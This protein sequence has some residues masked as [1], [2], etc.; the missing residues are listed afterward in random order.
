MGLFSFW[1]IAGNNAMRLFSF[2]YIVGNSV[3][4]LFSF[5]YIAGNSVMR[6]FSFWYIAASHMAQ[7]V[8]LYGTCT[9]YFLHIAGVISVLNI[10]PL[11]F[12]SLNIGNVGEC[13]KGQ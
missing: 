10:L 8:F 4:R 3:M 1:Y 7:I 6:L 11:T 9:L 12:F 2:W 13:C 5:W